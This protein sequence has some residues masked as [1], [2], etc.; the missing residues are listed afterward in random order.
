MGWIASTSGASRAYSLAGEAGTH[1]DSER[2][3]TKSYRLRGTSGGRWG[4]G[5]QRRIV[6]QTAVGT[7]LVPNYLGRESR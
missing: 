6:V 7:V 3:Q 2:P 5:L 1:R 4:S